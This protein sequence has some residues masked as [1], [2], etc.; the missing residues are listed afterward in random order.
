MQ[1]QLLVTKTDFCIPNLKRE[2]DHIS[3]DYEVAF[4]EDHPEL[5][6]T[7]HIRHSPNIFV[8]GDLAFRRQPAPLEL[9][10]FFQNR[11]Q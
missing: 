8:D 4:I 7:H 5:I 9:K 2:F 1:V 6:S 10:D 3:V 11:V